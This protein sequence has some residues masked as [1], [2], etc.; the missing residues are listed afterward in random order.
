MPTSTAA[1]RTKLSLWFVAESC[2]V[3]VRGQEFKTRSKRLD[4]ND[5]GCP[6]ASRARLTG[7]EMLIVPDE[8]MQSLDDAISETKK[9]LAESREAIQDLLSESNAKGNLR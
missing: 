3:A 5:Q 8:A 7:F 4:F 1:L 9:A 6:W 2:R